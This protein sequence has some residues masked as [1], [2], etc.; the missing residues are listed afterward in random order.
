MSRVGLRVRT[1]PTAAPAQHTSVSTNRLL[2]A[3]GVFFVLSAH[4][5]GA[6]TPVVHA[7]LQPAFSIKGKVIAEATGTALPYSTVIVDP[8]GGE[9]FTDEAGVF[10]YYDA[11]PGTYRVRVRQLGYIP[12][13]TTVQFSPDKP[14]P[15]F[16]LLRLPTALAEVQ[17][18][19]PPRRCI[20]PDELGYVN[21]E[22]LA[23]I[24]GEARKNADRERL[25]RKLYPFEYRLAQQHD[26]YDTRATTH[27]VKY[28]TMTFRSDDSWGYKKGKVVSG[29]RNKLFGDVRVMRLP[30]LGDLA[31]RRFLTAHCFKYSG[32]EE[33]GGI[34]VHRIDFQPLKNIIAPDVEG[35][36]FLDSASYIIR[37][38][39]FRLTRGGSI[40]PAVLRMEVITTYR[41]ILPNVALF[42]EIRSIQPLQLEAGSN[43]I[44]FRQT[45]Q[46]LSFKFLHGAPPGAE[47]EITRISAGRK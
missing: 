16:A 22:E 13:D 23:T 9:K 1:P 37:K 18:S 47:A 45:Q 19:A 12:L 40:K 6:Q 28:D 3:V 32:V 38:A 7:P 33:Q 41:E 14:V 24:L 44:E 4:S 46:L 11:A 29:D 27:A 30:T 42:D 10:Q 31:D 39:E 8:V 21:D 35:S 17:V 5:V 25:L 26:T 43:P 2:A 36:I 20:V 15:V 34:A